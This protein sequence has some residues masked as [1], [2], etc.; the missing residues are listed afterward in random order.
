MKEE[1][2]INKMREVQNLLANNRPIH[3]IEILLSMPALDTEIR[4]SLA[5]VKAKLN[6]IN[7]DFIRGLISI[8][9]QTIALNN[10]NL[11]LLSIIDE[12]TFKYEPFEL[13]EIVE[14]KKKN[15]NNKDEFKFSLVGFVN[16]GKSIYLTMLFDYLFYHKIK[17]YVVEPSD[18]KTLENIMKNRQIIESGKLLPRTV[19]FNLDSYSA[20]IIKKSLF[21]ARSK[22]LSFIDYS[23]EYFH[24]I[25]EHEQER[26]QNKISGSWLHDSEAF[27]H[28]LTSDVV[29][30]AI[31]VTNLFYKECK[32]DGYVYEPNRQEMNY[33]EAEPSGYR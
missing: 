26:N 2:Y 18:L 31:D 20:L 14:S 28:V 32:F 19:P 4:N 8:E 7:K 12:F 29:F 6:K 33:P 9:D 27:S 16:A 13:F 22:K 25:Y 23:G 17:G 3:V 21:R 11:S 15:I 1:D 10:I 5:L 24:R 30:I